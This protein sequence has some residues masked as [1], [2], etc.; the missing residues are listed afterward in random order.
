MA[1]SWNLNRQHYYVYYNRIA[2]GLIMRMICYGC[3]PRHITE[4]RVSDYMIA[5][6]LFY[7]MCDLHNHHD[8][9][10][11]GTHELRCK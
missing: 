9:T 5:E 4:M 6:Q 11:G 7:G 2:R 10:N 8:R 3:N 1:R